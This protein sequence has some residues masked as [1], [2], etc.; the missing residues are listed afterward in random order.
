MAFS[1]GAER[2][3]EGVVSPESPEAFLF[4][5][6]LALED[7]LNCC[8]QVVIDQA[9]EDAP[10]EVKGK[11]MGVEQGLLTLYRIGPDKAFAGVLGAHAEKLQIPGLSCNDS[12]GIAPVDLCFLTHI[13]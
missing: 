7:F 6:S 2:G 12:S 3:L 10:E 5:A 11:D 4:K 13:R 8:G 1:R 9:G